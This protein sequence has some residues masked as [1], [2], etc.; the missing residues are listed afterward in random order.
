MFHCSMP[1]RSLW[2]LR[3]CLSA[4]C[5]H[6]H[7]PFSHPVPPVVATAKGPALG[8]MLVHRVQVCST[9]LVFSMASWV[10]L[11]TGSEEEVLGV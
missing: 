5:I 2:E 8:W 9:M 6:L 11:P 3:I 4:S 10:L 1:S 7:G